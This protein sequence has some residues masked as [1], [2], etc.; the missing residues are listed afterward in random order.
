MKAEIK[1][2]V[3]LL[4]SGKVGIYDSN[5]GKLM[6]DCSLVLEGVV[7]EH[8]W[9]IDWNIEELQR[10]VDSEF[11]SVNWSMFKLRRGMIGR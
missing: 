7:K 9:K 8:E 4:D 1:G 10:L 11:N 3:F 5:S 6:I 2:K